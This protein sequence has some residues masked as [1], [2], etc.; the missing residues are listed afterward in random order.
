MSSCSFRSSRCLLLSQLLPLLFKQRGGQS[1]SH[2]G[3]FIHRFNLLPGL[4]PRWEGRL[5]WAFPFRAHSLYAEPK[6][7]WKM[8]RVRF[9]STH[10][11][12]VNQG[13]TVIQWQILYF[14]DNRS[15]NCRVYEISGDVVLLSFLTYPVKP[16]VSDLQCVS[17]VSPLA[18][19]SLP[20]QSLQQHCRRDTHFCGA[21]LQ[22]RRATLLGLELLSTDGTLWDTRR[23]RW[24]WGA[25]FTLI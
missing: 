3:L 20:L 11:L 7:K 23:W 6:N 9:H 8:A 2:H 24:G 19:L 4:L 1:Q 12:S 18:L 25:V 22:V 5:R 16:S 15:I 17:S 14:K 13:Q 10:V 21:A